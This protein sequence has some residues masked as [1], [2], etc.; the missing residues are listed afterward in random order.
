M[1]ATTLYVLSTYSLEEKHFKGDNNC[2]T[3]WRVA[4]F[5][6]FGKNSFTRNFDMKKFLFI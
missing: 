1:L 4:A 3:N 5:D 6:K 2:R